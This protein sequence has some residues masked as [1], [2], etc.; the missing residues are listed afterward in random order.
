MS[1]KI[2]LALLVKC[3]NLFEHSFVNYRTKKNIT[4]SIIQKLFTNPQTT[5]LRLPNI[6]ATTPRL[7]VDAFIIGIELSS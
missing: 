7:Y 6:D 4:K 1:N 5:A 3:V 2:A